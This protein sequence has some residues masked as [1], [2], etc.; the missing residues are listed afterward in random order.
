MGSLPS[1]AFLKAQAERLTSYLGDK[2]RFRLKSSS[3]LEALAKMYQQPDWNTLQ[4]LAGRDAPSMDALCSPE[5]FPLTWRDGRPDLTVNANDWYRHTLVV[6]GDLLERRTWLQ[7]QLA[8]QLT[9]KSPG[10]F[11]NAFGDEMPADLRE[12]LK[13]EGL[14]INLRQSTTAGS[15][16][17]NLL[18]DLPCDALGHMLIEIAYPDWR[19][20]DAFWYEQASFVL[21]LAARLMR[22]TRADVTLAALMTLITESKLETLLSKVSPE[23]KDAML[24]LADYVLP[25]DKVLQRVRGM[26]AA[27]ASTLNAQPELRLLFSENARAPGLQ[28]LIAKGRC[29]VIEAPEDSTGSTE[30]AVIRAWKATIENRILQPREAKQVGLVFG[31]GEVNGYLRQPMVRLLDQSRSARCAM[32]MT[33]PDVEPLKRSQAGELLLDNVRNQVH[34]NPD[35]PKLLRQLEVR[36]GPSKVALAQPGSLTLRI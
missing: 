21:T 23:R 5:S 27:I 9:R 22:E 24:L 31:L 35:V 34:F 26:I 18:A 2:H 33:A 19:N 12:H 17:L 29:L 14:L 20:E 13:A 16:S 1:I 3:A 30:N 28:T 6:G 11:L 10:L 4:A 8:Q 32:L 7:Q 25:Q 15:L 36:N